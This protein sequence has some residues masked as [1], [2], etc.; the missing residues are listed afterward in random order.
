MF[1]KAPATLGLGPAM[2]RKQV[3]DESDEYGAEEQELC[4]SVRLWQFFSVR[5]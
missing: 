1:G 2:L 5:P 3:D 4:L